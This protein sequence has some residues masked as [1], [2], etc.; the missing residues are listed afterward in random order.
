MC[1]MHVDY[2]FLNVRF[3]LWFDAIVVFETGKSLR[4]KI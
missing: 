1:P 3:F 2:V 4:D